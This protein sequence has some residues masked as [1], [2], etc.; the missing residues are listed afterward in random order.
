MRGVPDYRRYGTTIDDAL[1]EA[2]DKTA[3]LL[4]LGYP[5]GPQ[6]ET[7]AQTGNPER[8]ALPR[9]LKGTDGCNFSFSGLKT[10]VRQT[11]QRLGELKQQDIADI[12]AGFQQAVCETLADRLTNAFTH[13]QREFPDA[14]KPTLVVAGGV[15]ANRT[16]RGALEDLC[17]Q[18]GWRIIAPPLE[19][20]GDNA[21]M[22]AWAGAERLVRGL[23]D[24]LDVA[25]RAR[26]S[27][28]PK[29]EPAPFAGVKA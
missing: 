23:T 10:A 3:K 2:F 13:F 7:A 1:G 16:I 9:P 22:V 6:V 27:L 24:D 25:A 21:A 15:A 29:A 11:A 17:T 14:V 18:D 5:G 19:L 12:C 4:G 20:C 28:D 8:F 26:W